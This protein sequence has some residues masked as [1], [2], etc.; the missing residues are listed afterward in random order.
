MFLL[1]I[2]H[3]YNTDQCGIQLA[4]IVPVLFLLDNSCFNAENM[5]V[6]AFVSQETVC[7]IYDKLRRQ[8]FIEIITQLNYDV[9]N[10]P[11]ITFVFGYK[12]FALFKNILY[13]H[14]SFPCMTQLI[15]NSVL[16]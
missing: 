12:M 13:F 1:P 15:L 2:I 7:V 3:G 5:L 10:M 6:D 16:I 11:Y 4:I 14:F 9:I 8:P